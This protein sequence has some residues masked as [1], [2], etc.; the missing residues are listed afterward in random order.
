MENE[1]MTISNPASSLVIIVGLVLFGV[2]L[3]L[4]AILSVITHSIVLMILDGAIGF[5]IFSMTCFREFY[6]KPRSVVFNNDGIQII[7]RFPKRSEF[8]PFVMMRSIVINKSSVGS[9]KNRPL[10]GGGIY[11]KGRYFPILISAEIG[12]EVKNKY[13][14]KLGEK[15][16]EK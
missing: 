12:L 1:S 4:G 3:L 11:L 7:N 10:S 14:E 5:L 13:R 9:S 16:P 8:I 2:F 6:N 15:L